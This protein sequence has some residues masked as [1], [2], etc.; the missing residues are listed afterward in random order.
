MEGRMKP[1]SIITKVFQLAMC[2]ALVFAV[3]SPGST[4]PV[5]AE[6]GEHIFEAWVQVRNNLTGYVMINGVEV[7]GPP[8]E[9]GFWFE[10]GDG[11][12]THS[13]FPAEH[14]YVDTSQVYVVTVTSVYMDGSSEQTTVIVDFSEPQGYY[15]QV[16]IED[17]DFY[18]GEVSVTGFVEGAGSL[19]FDWGD[20]NEPET[21]EFDPRSP[22]PVRHQYD[23]KTQHYTIIVTANYYDGTSESAELDV[24]FEWQEVGSY[25]IYVF[26]PQTGEIALITRNLPDSDKYNPSWS[27]NGK[28][29]AHDVVIPGV[30]HGIY[31][32]DV[33][34]GI[35]TPLVGAQDGGNDAAWSPNGKWIVFDRV[36]SDDPSLYLVP[37]VGGEATLVREDA[38]SADWAPSGRRL[39]F[40]Q[41]SDGSIRTAPVDGGREAE[42]IIAERGANP[43]WSPDGNWIA[44]E[45]DGD[46]WKQQVNVL[47][48]VFGEPIQVT[49]GPFTHGQPTWSLDSQA[50]V[51]H[52]AFGG[53]FDLWSVPAEGGESTWLNGAPI[54]GDYDPAY[55]RNSHLVAYASPSPDGQ[56]PRDWVAAFTYDLPANSWT[57][58]THTYQFY[59]D[60]A[61][62]ITPGFAFVV[63]SDSPVYEGAVLIRGGN[64]LR[65]WTG[66]GC[67]SIDDI[68]PNQPARFH[69]GWSMFGSYAEALAF[70]ANDFHV[71]WDGGERVVMAGHTILPFNEAVDW[72]GY[73]CSFTFP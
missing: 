14:V 31:I 65:A 7:G 68:H 49:S 67:E 56:A 1:M 16:W 72:G 41:P 55:A 40:Q 43:A 11:T 15:M 62:I 48:R 53:D 64:V 22:L 38:V 9:G 18:S 34:T 10:W 44:Y 24:E 20:G 50:I 21:F 32:T 54:F 37:A 51:F 47:G 17:V 25:E 46:I 69:V 13:W 60:F 73:V 6:E 71:A 3:L 59:V 35:S 52:S 5:S 45:L 29:I 63:S 61:D 27:Q 19:T 8:G 66:A 57:T 4:V 30:S 36:P 39:V 28:W 26:D 12:E 70:Y 23:D 33:K 2:L 42:T 58:G